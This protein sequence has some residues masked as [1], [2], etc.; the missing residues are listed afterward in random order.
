MTTE[1]QTTYYQMQPFQFHL[2]MTTGTPKPPNLKG[3]SQDRFSGRFTGSNAPNKY[4]ST[5]TKNPE[6]YGQIQWNSP[7]MFS[8]CKA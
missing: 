3:L 6:K 8:M 5:I 1:G 7:G 4:I 2:L